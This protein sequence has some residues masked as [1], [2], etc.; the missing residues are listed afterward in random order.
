MPSPTVMKLRGKQ[1]DKTVATSPAEREKKKEIKKKSE[2]ATTVGPWVLALLLF[3]VV[4][5]AFLNI[6]QNIN[7]SPSMSEAH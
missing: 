5:S 7:N 3:A 1:L 6:F 4:G 2:N